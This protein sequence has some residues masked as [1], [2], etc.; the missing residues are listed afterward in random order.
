MVADIAPESRERVGAL[1]S[2][3]PQ[4]VERAEV[5]DVRFEERRAVVDIRYANDHE[6]VVLRS[7]WERRGDARRPLIV[8]AEL[9]GDG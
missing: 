3:L 7:F 1:A 5:V 8:E 4:P 6:E 2:H 9:A